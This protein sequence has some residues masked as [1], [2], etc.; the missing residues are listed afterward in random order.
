MHRDIVTVAPEGSV[1]IGSNDNCECQA[2]IIPE[3]VLSV[4]GTSLIYSMLTSGHPEFN[5]AIVEFL[6]ENRFGKGLFGKDV[7]DEALPHAADEDDGIKVGEG[8]MNFIL[9]AKA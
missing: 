4:Q 6:L 2:L 7:F 8:I 1:I 9:S 5:Q 3:R